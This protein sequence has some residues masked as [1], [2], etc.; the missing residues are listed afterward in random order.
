MA[1]IKGQGSGVSFTYLLLLAG[2]ERIKP[3]RMILRFLADA[4][5]R[6]SSTD[7]VEQILALVGS[8]MAVSVRNLDHAIWSYQRAHARP[9]RGYVRANC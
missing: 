3:D 9:L 1:R 4:L 5:E 7:E 8:K 6:T 2:A